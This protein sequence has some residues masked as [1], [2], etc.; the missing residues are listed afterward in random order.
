MVYSKPR[1]LSCRWVAAH[2]RVSRCNASRSYS[3]ARRN[4][5]FYTQQDLDYNLTQSHPRL[6]TCL[7]AAYRVLCDKLSVVP[8]VDVTTPF[9][10]ENNYIKTYA[11]VFLVFFIYGCALNCPASRTCVAPMLSSLS[12]YIHRTTEPS[13]S[14]QTPLPLKTTRPVGSPTISPSRR[15][16]IM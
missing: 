6:H 5:L 4:R 7:R 15:N 9:T 2:S 1:I 14:T 16:S 8:S 11:I 13:P 12:S 10:D 3:H